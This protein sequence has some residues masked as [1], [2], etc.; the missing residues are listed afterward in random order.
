MLWAGWRGPREES[1]ACLF[2]VLGDVGGATPGKKGPKSPFMALGE[3]MCNI[4]GY[5]QAHEMRS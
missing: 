1:S 3:L 4:L 5:K 2:S